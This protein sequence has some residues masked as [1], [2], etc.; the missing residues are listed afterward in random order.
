MY[1]GVKESARG[2]SLL[3]C[4]AM[5]KKAEITEVEVGGML[6]EVGNAMAALHSAGKRVPDDIRNAF[7]RVY[8]DLMAEVEAH[9]FSLEVFVPS[10]ANIAEHLR[11]SLV[12]SKIILPNGCALPST[13]R[14]KQLPSVEHKKISAREQCE[15][16]VGS[17][18]RF[19]DGYQLYI[20]QKPAMV[21]EV[22][23]NSVVLDRKNFDIGP[24]DRFGDVTRI[25]HKEF[26]KELQ[27]GKIWV[28]S[29]HDIE[30]WNV[31]DAIWQNEAI[32][33]DLQT[34]Q[35]VMRFYDLIL[36][37]AAQFELPL[38]RDETPERTSARIIEYLREILAQDCERL[39]KLTMDL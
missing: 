23:S 3:S 14:V 36:T 37:Y 15:S 12:E 30:V 35:D 5:S 22:N 20:Q 18:I 24:R 17:K 21:V 8:R 16:Y 2:S 13:V 27:Q 34:E 19:G 1:D 25:E 4:F 38:F 6:T 10:F 9:N 31:K 7:M 33:D 32:I 26:L 28:V 11:R 29:E 39:E